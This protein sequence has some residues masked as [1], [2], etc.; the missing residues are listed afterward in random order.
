MF[1]KYIKYLVIRRIEGK[2]DEVYSWWDNGLF[3]GTAWGSTFSEYY[4][5][6]KTATYS[7]GRSSLQVFERLDEK[8]G[9]VLIDDLTLP[10]DPSLQNL[11][12][13]A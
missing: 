7:I 11:M 9:F 1:E 3:V 13:D 6:L 10:S 2:E 12:V 4:E 8:S 5:G